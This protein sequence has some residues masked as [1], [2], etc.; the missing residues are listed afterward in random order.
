[1][2]G[3][4]EFVVQFKDDQGQPADVGDVQMGSS[5]S[6]PAWPPCRGIPNSH[7]PAKPEFTSD[8]QL[9]DER[10]MALHCCLERAIWPKATQPSTAT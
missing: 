1:M 6:S 7:P 10:G 5:M 4:N 3:Q 2:Q 8:F 9:R